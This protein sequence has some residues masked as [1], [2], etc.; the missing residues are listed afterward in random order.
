MLPD[1]RPLTDWF[2]INRRSYNWRESN[3]PYKVWVSEVMSQQTR[4]DTIGAYFSRFMEQFPTVEDLAMAPEVLV[5]KMWEGLGYYSRA[6]NLHK[7]A[8]IIV[9]EYG[10]R[11]PESAE[12]LRKLPGIGAYTAGAIA[13]FCFGEAEPAVDGNVVRITCRLLDLDFSQGDIKDRNETYQILKNYMSSHPEESPADINESFMTLGAMICIPRTPKCENCP[14]NDRCL[15]LKSGRATLLPYKK[16]AKKTPVEAVTYLILE[17]RDR[18]FLLGR[19]PEGLLHGLWQHL[20]LDGHYT[21]EELDLRL[22]MAGLDV[23]EL[24]Y[25]GECRHIFSHLVWDMEV[26]HAVLNQDSQDPALAS[27]T[28]IDILDPGENEELLLS[29]SIEPYLAAPLLDNRAWLSSEEAG[30]LPFSS[31]LSAFLPWKDSADID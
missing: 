1:L 21:E 4:A 13:S 9:E 27:L 29:D 6:R 10:G 3:E 22:D 25:Q 7:S 19:R 11:F 23:S 5:L 28:V 18:R 30:R 16:I 12:L 20:A 14:V 2:L 31:A 26:W 24:R 15:A 8:K 17:S